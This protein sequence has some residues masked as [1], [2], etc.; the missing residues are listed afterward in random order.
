MLCLYD[1]LMYLLVKVIFQS[2]DETKL[3]VS[4]KMLHCHSVW[5]TESCLTSAARGRHHL[6]GCGCDIP[7][8]QAE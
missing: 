4:Q 1:S 2:G 3:R 5:L 6:P 8:S 7:V